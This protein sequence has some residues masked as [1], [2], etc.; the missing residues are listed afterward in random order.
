[1]INREAWDASVVRAIASHLAHQGLTLG[2]ARVPILAY[3]GRGQGGGEYLFG[4]K[5]RQESY[6]FREYASRK[7]PGITPRLV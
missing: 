7:T 5:N 3:S 6:L 1:M 4:S 2:T